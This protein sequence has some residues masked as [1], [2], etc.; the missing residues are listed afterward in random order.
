VPRFE[1]SRVTTL[2]GRLRAV[3]QSVTEDLYG[4]KLTHD[5]G[6]SLRHSDIVDYVC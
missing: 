1:P 4:W 5:A 3:T 6:A 2:S